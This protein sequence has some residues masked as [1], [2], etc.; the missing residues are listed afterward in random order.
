MSGRRIKQILS[1][2]HV[3]SVSREEMMEEIEIPVVVNK[4][5]EQID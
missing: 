1:F 2:L 4:T 5:W 3:Q